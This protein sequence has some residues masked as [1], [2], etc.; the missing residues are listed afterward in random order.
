MKMF[1]KYLKIQKEVKEQDILK[2]ENIDMICRYLAPQQRCRG[3]LLKAVR[4]SIPE[5]TAICRNY[6]IR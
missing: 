2:L 5:L 4:Q 3:I 6:Q 1:K